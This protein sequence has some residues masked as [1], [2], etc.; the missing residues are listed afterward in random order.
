MAPQIEAAASTYPAGSAWLASVVAQA[1]FF[2][3][4]LGVWLWPDV[5]RMAIDLPP[6][7][8][9]LWAPGWAPIA[10]AAFVAHGAAA[11]LLLLRGRGWPRLLGYG[12]LFAWIAFLVELSSVRF[13]EPFVL[14]RSYL[15]APGLAIAAA[16]V[17]GRLP[18]A[19]TL[20]GGVAVLAILF[21]GATDR[22][23]TFASPLAL[24]QD[25]AR[26]LPAEA[27][28][29]GARTLF[30]LAREQFYA[31]QADNALAT[32]DACVA[33]HPE[34]FYCYFGRGSLRLQQGQFERAL[35]DLERA[36]ALQAD[37]GMAHHHRGV[38]LQGMGRLREARAEYELAGKF[39]FRP[40]AY[41]L[42]MLD[43]IE[44]RPSPIRS[45]APRP[46]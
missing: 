46:D 20:A 4:Y 18:R 23:A 34:G 25:A 37:S 7:L 27:V 14:Y 28:P 2:F 35:P 39:N 32:S 31:G 44:Q 1:G 12:L 26:K 13:Q 42:R 24:W 3:R 40:A 16:A 38:A 11:G 41:R 8:D 22:L 21:Y 10:L 43:E 15:W 5:E 17:L 29:G 9:A 36:L 33:K 6:D 45:A 30:N 19:T